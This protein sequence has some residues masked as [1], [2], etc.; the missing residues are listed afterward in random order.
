[1]GIDA[2]ILVVYIVSTVV[3]FVVAGMMLKRGS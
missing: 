1:M 2:T 3:S